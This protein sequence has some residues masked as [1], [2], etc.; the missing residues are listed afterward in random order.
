MGFHRR[1]HHCFAS[2]SMLAWVGRGLKMALFHNLRS[3]AS[4]GLSFI[5]LRSLLIYWDHVFLGL[6]CP[7]LSSTTTCLQ[8]LARLPASI[9]ITCPNHLSLFLRSTTVMSEFP[10]FYIFIFTFFT[11]IYLF[12]LF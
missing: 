6:P 9:L 7:R 5:L 11:F 4:L 3:R 10:V 2:V 1:H 8:A 12:S